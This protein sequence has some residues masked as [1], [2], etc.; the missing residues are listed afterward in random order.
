MEPETTEPLEESTPVPE[1]E[2]EP[3]NYEDEDFIDPTPSDP[4]DKQD[5]LI[6]LS[7]KQNQSLM[8]QIE[9]DKILLDKVN[10]KLDTLSTKNSEGSSALNTNNEQIL[11]KLDQMIENQVHSLSGSN[12]IVTYGVLYIPLAIICFLLWRFF[13]T[14]IRSAR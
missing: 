2:P 11:V 6:Y 1:P 9:Q 10:E 7:E 4:V 3:I 8:D 14:F 12:T 5:V 13:A